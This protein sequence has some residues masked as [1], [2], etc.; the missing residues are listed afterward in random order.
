MP[1]EIIAEVA[2]GYEGDAVLARL[3]TKG[4]V[5][6]G[7]DAIKFQLVYADELATRD[8]IHYDLFRSLEMPREAWQKVAE[9]TKAGGARLYLDIYGE[10]SLRE[11]ADLGADGIKIST[12]EFFNTRLVHSALDKMPRVFV[13]LG[14]ISLEEMERFRDIHKLAPGPQVCF[15]YGFQAEPTAIESNNLRRF[16]SLKERFPGYRF[17]F[18]D[19]ADG[20]S[21]DAM[22][23]ALVAL[24]I[25]IDCV[26]KH[27]SL[28]RILQLEDWVSALSPE[29]F[30]MFVQRIRH[31]EKAL[32][33]DDLELTPIESEYRYK[34][35]KVVVANRM[36]KKGEIV[37]ADNLCLKR[38]SRLSSPSMIYRLEQVVG[39]T[40]AVDVQPDEAIT[41]EV[42]L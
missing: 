11:A 17:G 19:H 39:H 16:R 14:G 22:T 1:V 20:G 21:E 31:L 37:A 38:T 25:G 7:V 15:M 40:L 4:A 36:L 24:G 5:R 12:T 9:E 41:K 26:E 18:M 2:Q 13:S 3:L 33:T 28:D 32:G 30:K 27:I 42:L 23:L 10:R 6:A 35:V 34:A 29:Q 8:Y